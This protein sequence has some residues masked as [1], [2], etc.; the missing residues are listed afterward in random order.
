MPD[1]R[2]FLAASAIIDHDHPAVRDKARELAEGRDDSIVIAE[3]CFL[4]VRDEVRHSG[5]YSCGPVTLRASEVLHHRTG[6]CYAKSHLLAALLRANGIPAGLCYQR[7]LD[8]PPDR[9]FCLHGLNAVFLQGFGWYRIDA[10]GNKTGIDAR[11]AP[12]AEY[13][14]Y[15][16]MRP[17]ET[18]NP[19]IFANPV[20]VVIDVLAQYRDY[21]EV[22]FNLPDCTS[23]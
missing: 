5:D 16:P 21:R 17:G 20:Q 2:A 22:L 19:G 10:R 15:S 9:P 13:L 12:P 14:A 3:R 8:N 11:F 7:L 23:L 1:P 18:D 6:F 4:F